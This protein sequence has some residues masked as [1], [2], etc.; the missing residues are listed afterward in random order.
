MTAAL[1]LV[2]ATAAPL[3]PANAD[4]LIGFYAGGAVGQGRV[5]ASA[6][7]FQVGAFRANHSAY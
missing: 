2:G 5:A 7:N 4:D 6:D 3:A 1:L